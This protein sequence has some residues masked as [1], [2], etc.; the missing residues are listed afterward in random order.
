MVKNLHLGLDSG[1]YLLACVAWDGMASIGKAVGHEDES[2]NGEESDNLH[3]FEYKTINFCND[4]LKYQK[5]VS[6]LI[7]P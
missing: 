2:D 4:L 3:L 1:R 7:V 5:K 6:N